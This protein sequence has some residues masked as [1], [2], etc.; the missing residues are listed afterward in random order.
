MTRTIASYPNSL[1][2][3]LMIGS[4]TKKELEIVQH[5]ARG[6]TASQTC[7]SMDINVGTYRSHKYRIKRKMLGMPM[8]G[9][10][11]VL[12]A[13]EGKLDNG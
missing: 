10:P 9:W 7:A 1:E 11:A 8:W 13:V 2:A 3:E 5:I 12:F 4:L 6:C